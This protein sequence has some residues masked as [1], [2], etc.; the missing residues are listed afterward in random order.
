MLIPEPVVFPA[1]MFPV[2]RFEDNLVRVV[3]IEDEGGVVPIRMCRLENALGDAPI[4]QPPRED[5]AVHR[6]LHRAAADDERD[7][8]GKRIR[9]RAGERIA[10][11]TSATWMPAPTASWMAARLASG[12]WPRLSSSVPSTSIPISRI[13]RKTAGNSRAPPGGAKPTG[14]R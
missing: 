2:H 4:E 12:R 11:V 9:N 13:T 6:P 14:L 5:G 8:G 10:P 1:R 3:A 7:C